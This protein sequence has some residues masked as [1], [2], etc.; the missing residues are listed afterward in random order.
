MGVSFELEG[1]ERALNLL[2]PNKV[3]AAATDSINRVA[4]STKAKAS[5]IIRNDEGWK[6][7]KRDLDK[8]LAY[9]KA[10]K[11][12]LEAVLY[13]RRVSGKTGRLTGKESFPLTYFGA[14]E[15]R[16]SANQVLMRKRGKEG[17]VTKR[18]KRTKLPGGVRVK[19]QRGENYARYPKA[20][21]ARMKSGH[22]GVFR[23]VE[24]GKWGGKIREIRTVGVTTMFAN[25]EPRL[26]EHAIK[27][28]RKEFPAKL[29]HHFRM[30]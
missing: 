30:R 7:K 25:I 15:V 12:H 9:T 28:W 27:R 4:A 20:F 26:E 11:G 13:P 8:R 18:Q 2:D 14:Q 6:I 29:R 3:E 17:L 1:L 19:T 23:N 22:V 21:I 5:H 10:R 16:K 24:G